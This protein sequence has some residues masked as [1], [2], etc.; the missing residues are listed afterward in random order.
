MKNSD[1]VQAVSNALKILEILSDSAKGGASD[2]AR[3][4]GCQKS[5]AFRLLQTLREAG[6]IV[7]DETDEKYS[8]SLKLFRIG[9][10]AVNNLDL[11]KEALPVITRLS[12]L[13]SETIHLCTIDNDQLVYL[14]K[15]ESTY[16]L[17]VSMMSRVGQSTPFYCTGVGKVLLAYQDAEKIQ[18]YLRNTMFERF[19]ES[20]ITNSLELA[21]ELER[22]RVS[23]FAYDNEEHELGV[24]CVA[25]PVFDRQ[26]KILAAVSIS[27]PSIRLANEKLDSF[28]DLVQSAARE[29]S[30]KMGF[31]G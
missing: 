26:G 9:S 17:K 30:V 15:I 6:Y 21:A 8:L 2:I 24:Q 16:A 11:N 5:T 13:T 3:A 27:G 19:T 7:Q 10:S 1:T 14:Q 18:H 31:I 28:R 20:T 23:G 22:I 29:I 25:A 4:I 12:Q